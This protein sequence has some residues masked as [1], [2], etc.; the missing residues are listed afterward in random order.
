MFRISDHRTTREHCRSTSPAVFL[1]LFL[2]LLLLSGFPLLSEAMVSDTAKSKYPL[3]D[4]RNPDCPCHQ[5]QRMADEEYR[6][7][8]NSGN[9]SLDEGN[10]Q[11]H[12]VK[13][14]PGRNH[15]VTASTG[16]K[17]KRKG[18][19]KKMTYWKKRHFNRYKGAKKIRLDPAS[20][21][22]WQT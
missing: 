19:M 7:S 17:K 5:Y 12:Q 15:S 11:D 2:F 9:R 21:Y 14:E 3:N 13:G 22:K 20:C 1:R 18:K 16:I 8:G 10:Q 4:P 6:R